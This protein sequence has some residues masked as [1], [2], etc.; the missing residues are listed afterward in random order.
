MCEVH[1]VII[2]EKNWAPSVDQYRLQALQFLV[3]PIDLLGLLQWLRQQRICLQCRRPRFNPWVGKIP[4]R[5]EQ[6]PSPVFLP[7]ESHGQGNLA[8]YSPWDC[9]RTELSDFHFISLHF[10][11]L[12]S[13][14]IRCNDFTG[15]QKAVVDQSRSRSRPTVTMTFFFF[16]CKFGFGK[17]F[18]ASLQSN[19]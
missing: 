5:R 2:L 19:H 8:G 6:Q 17:C 12:L 9:S 16:W 15:I 1:S 11:D 3:H 10:I 4:W 7:Q 13:I 14:L 18:G